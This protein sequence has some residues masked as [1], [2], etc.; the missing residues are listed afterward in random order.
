[1]RLTQVLS[2]S[3]GSICS[4]QKNYYF[5]LVTDGSNSIPNS[6]T[7]ESLSPLTATKT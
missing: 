3:G 2:N 5:A 7:A 6:F 4:Q 1:M